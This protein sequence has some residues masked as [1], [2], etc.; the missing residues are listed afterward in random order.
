MAHP[1]NPIEFRAEE[2]KRQPAGIAHGI[3]GGT[4]ELHV[5][6]TGADRDDVEDESETALAAADADEDE[7]FV[8]IGGGGGLGMDP[9]PSIIARYSHDAGLVRVRPRLEL[10]DLEDCALMPVLNRSLAHKLHSIE[11]F[12]NG[13]KLMDIGRDEFRIDESPFKNIAADAFTPEELDDPWVRIRSVHES[14]FHLRFTSS[15]PRRLYGDARH[16]GA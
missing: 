9:V 12:A 4:W 3:S 15:T 8:F 2:K 11:V 14:T 10:R 6:V 5:N 1:T 13:Y 7:K 16:T